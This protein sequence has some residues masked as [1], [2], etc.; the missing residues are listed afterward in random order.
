MSMPVARPTGSSISST[1]RCAS[2]AESVLRSC[3]SRRARASY[4]SITSQ[5]SAAIGA[6]P[7]ITAVR[8]SCTAISG[9]ALGR[10]REIFLQRGD[11]E[12]LGLEQALEVLARID[13]TTRAQDPALVDQR[14]ER[15][16][17]DLMSQA[18]GRRPDVGD[19][20][21]SL[22]THELALLADV[23]I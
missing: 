10:A 19:P 6:G 20:L 12:P 9:D 5:T 7:C 13:Q 21:E 2:S 3:A 8:A 22:R 18:E 1:R 11:A 23:A 17:A 15:Q 16:T 4:S 14:R